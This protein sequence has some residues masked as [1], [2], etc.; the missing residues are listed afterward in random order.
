LEKLDK[1]KKKFAENLTKSL[2]KFAE[3]LQAR[4]AFYQMSIV[5]LAWTHRAPRKAF[6]TLFG[7]GL[8]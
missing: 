7:M 6:P 8:A 3:S 4:G 1:T 2:E 5:I